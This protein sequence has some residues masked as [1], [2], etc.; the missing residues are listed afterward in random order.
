MQP[1][2]DGVV[3]LSYGLW[4]QRFGG[5]RGVI[6]RSLNINGRG[7]T[8]IGVMQRG[9]DYPAPAEMW[10]P[11]SLDPHARTRRDLH[12]L[13]VI[14]RL[15]GGATIEQARAE[16][17]TF[18]ARLAAQYPDFDKDE[19]V[20]VNSIMDD[21]TG[22]VR[23]ALLV[24]VGA[25]GFLLLIACAN[26]ANLLLAKASGRQREM[27]I[28]ASLGA[29]RS[30]VLA[31]ML[32][33]S[34]ILALLGGAAGLALTAVAFHALL[35]LAPA[36]VPRLEDVALNWRVVEVSLALSLATGIL[37]GF[38]PAWYAARIDVNSMLKEGSR[39]SSG[40]SRVRSVLRRPA[41]SRSRW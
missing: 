36:N 28:R 26:I 4:Q 20:V 22:N 15:N 18:S 34:S 3:V 33:E 7:R 10:S 30:T 17:Q 41:R 12:T 29:G 5:D 9:F 19:S 37:F 38:A 14:G 21:L 1:G 16:F 8:V 2:R 35:R 24:L 23:P 31:Q 6:G 13:R 40:R 39:T 25:V 11:L 32:T 27:A